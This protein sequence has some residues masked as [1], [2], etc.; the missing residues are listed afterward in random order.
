[1]KLTLAPIFFKAAILVHQPQRGPTA[2]PYTAIEG[3]ASSLTKGCH[4]QKLLP[5]EDS[6]HH[7]KYPFLAFLIPE[8]VTVAGQ[9]ICAAFMTEANSGSTTCKN[10]LNLVIKSGRLITDVEQHWFLL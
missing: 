5:A 1:V 3:S 8:F 6:N 4:G 2:F 7:L 9:A 10:S